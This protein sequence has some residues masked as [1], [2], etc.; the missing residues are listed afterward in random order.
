MVRSNLLLENRIPDLLIKSFL[1]M[2]GEKIPS[3]LYHIEAL[4]FI[5]KEAT[6][7]TRL[8]LGKAISVKGLLTGSLNEIPTIKYLK[9]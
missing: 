7:Q 6:H 2:M 3:L 8:N 1:K 4:K 9:P 5:S